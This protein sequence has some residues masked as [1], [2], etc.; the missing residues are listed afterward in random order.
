MWRLQSSSGVKRSRGTHRRMVVL[1][2]A[3]VLAAGAMIA[4][5]S[6][7]AEPDDPC[8]SRATILCRFLPMAPDLDGDVDMT[9]ELPPSGPA[10]GENDPMPNYD[11]CRMGCI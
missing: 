4:A 7:A 6:A 11:A 3:T 5:P 2:S 8:A 10:P 1:G 9:S